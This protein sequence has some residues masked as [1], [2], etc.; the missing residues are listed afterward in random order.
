MK[1]I[2]KQVQLFF[3]KAK[4]VFIVKTKKED[5]YMAVLD[6]KIIRF[7]F[8]DKVCKKMPEAALRGILAHELA[9]IQYPTLKEKEIDR[10]IVELGFKADLIAFHKWHNKRYPRYDKTDDRLTLKQVKRLR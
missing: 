4:R 6:L 10:K 7:L 8:V 9:H 5:F 1:K 2:F 3:P